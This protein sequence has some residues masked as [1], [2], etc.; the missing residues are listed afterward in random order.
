MT[1]PATRWRGAIPVPTA[2]TFV[3]LPQKNQ[4][5]QQVRLRVNTVGPLMDYYQQQ[6]GVNSFSS[7][8]IN[9]FSGVGAGLESRSFAAGGS[10][11]THPP[12]RWR[13]DKIEVRTKLFRLLARAA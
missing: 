4:R 9:T 3:L 1:A 12:W 11:Y 10:R 8:L 2:T 7:H 13:K 5:E 6:A